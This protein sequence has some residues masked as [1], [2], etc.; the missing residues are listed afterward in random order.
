MPDSPQ[1]LADRLLLE[2]GRVVEFFN[3]I[4]TLQWSQ[5]AYPGQGD[6]NFHTLLA[7]FLSAE[8]GR[9]EL[10]R[11]VAQGG[12]GAPPDFKID[13]Y[14]LLGVTKL[15]EESNFTLLDDFWTERVKLAEFVASLSQNDLERQG[16]DPFLGQTTLCEMIKLTYR[17]NQIHFREVRGNL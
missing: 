15:N 16:N 7:H 4:R 3:Q 6:W 5:P 17:H 2:G 8:L 9:G 1:S 13:E 10:I 14:K 11:Q 12:P